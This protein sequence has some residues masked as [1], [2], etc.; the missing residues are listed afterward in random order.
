[1]RENRSSGSEGG[2]A[3]RLPYPYEP[4]HF[5]GGRVWSTAFRRPFSMQV[6]LRRKSRLKAGLRAGTFRGRESLEYRL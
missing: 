1:M 4:E 3:L 6:A 5:E 2:E